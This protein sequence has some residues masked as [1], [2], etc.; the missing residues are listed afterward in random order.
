MMAPIR[1]RFL[2]EI[3]K[4]EAADLDRS[5]LM[6]FNSQL[7]AASQRVPRPEGRRDEA[8]T[9]PS[10]GQRGVRRQ[11]VVVSLTEPAIGFSPNRL[12]TSPQLGS[13][14]IITSK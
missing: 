5:L 10:S 12:P 3:V 13:P 1:T 6:S 9:P 14:I 8:V 4:Q 2:W 7:P 11:R